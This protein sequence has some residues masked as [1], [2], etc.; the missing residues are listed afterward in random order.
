MRMQGCAGWL[1]AVLAGCAACGWA[2]DTAD[3]LAEFGK[4]LEAPVAAAPKPNAE[5]AAA[6]FAQAAP[7]SGAGTALDLTGWAGPLGFAHLDG[8][9]DAPAVQTEGYFACDSEAL[10]AAVRCFEPDLDAVQGKAGVRDGNVWHSDSVELMVLPGLEVSSSY[11]H[12]ATDA[13]GTLYDARVNDASWQSNA[14]VRVVRGEGHWTV[15]F[16]VP[17]ADLGV[18]AASAPAVWRANLHR[19][20]PK[21]GGAAALDLAWSPTRGRSNHVPARFGVLHLDGLG[22]APDAAALRAFVAQSER[23]EIVFRQDF[24]A[25]RDGFGGGEVVRAP[26]GQPASGGFLRV[27]NARSVAWERSFAAP[28][29]VQIAFAYRTAPGQHGLVVHGSGSV[30]R[31][32]RPGLVEVF[33]RGLKVAQSTCQD[34]DGQS[35]SFDLGFDAFR[36]KRPYGH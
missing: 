28:Q 10:Y 14:T 22:R 34:A 18:T 1:G 23:V 3:A 17:L 8:T 15:L 2:A 21:R 20:R 4:R 11:Y 29:G 32:C 30:V 27:S 24:A 26:D 19:A 33:G 35:R 9:A 13:A 7:K 5:A 25:N 12:F 6:L 31:A 36:F 16:K